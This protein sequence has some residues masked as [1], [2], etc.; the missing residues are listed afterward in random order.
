LTDKI[1]ATYALKNIQKVKP[2][3][4]KMQKSAL[5]PGEVE[6]AARVGS[7]AAV[8]GSGWAR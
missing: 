4:R 2:V 5:L 6:A 3:K 7:R 8:S 1:N